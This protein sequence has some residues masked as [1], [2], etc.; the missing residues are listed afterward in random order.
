MVVFTSITFYI[1]NH[2]HDMNMLT[3]H[4]YN[5]HGLVNIISISIWVGGEEPCSQL[6][7][8]VFLPTFTY[9]K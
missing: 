8:F 6:V 7:A 2:T 4:T 5:D 3:L 1:I 9:F